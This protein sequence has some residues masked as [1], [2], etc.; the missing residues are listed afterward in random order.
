MGKE[1]VFDKVLLLADEAADVKVGSPYIA[2]AKVTATSF[3][4]DRAKKVRVVKY[5]EK[6]VIVRHMDIGR[7][8]TKVRLLI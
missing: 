5:K 4:Q 3:A 7:R 8:Y 6:S 2:G 1:A